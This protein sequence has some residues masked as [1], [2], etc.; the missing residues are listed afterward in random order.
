MNNY[1]E[2]LWQHYFA[3][4]PMK[5]NEKEEEIIKKYNETEVKLRAALTQEQNHLLEEYDN[6][7]CRVNGISEKNAFIKGVRLGLHLFLELLCDG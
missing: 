3:E 2:Q 5:R 4:I 7:V 6:A 1:L